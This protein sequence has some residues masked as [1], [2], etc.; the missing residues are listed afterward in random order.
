MLRSD[1]RA[2]HEY[3]ADGAVL[4]QGINARQYQYLLITKAASIGGYSLANGISHS[5]LKNR[6]NMMLHTKSPSQRYFK[7]LALLPIVAMALAVNAETVT[8]Y[9]YDE[10]QKQVP[11]K[12]GVK[13]GTIKMGN[14]EIKVVKAEE[15]KAETAET[16]TA[17]GSFEP[18]K[19]KAF[20]VVEEMP[21]YPGG[22]SKLFEYLARSVK[23]P[24]AAEKAGV[25][26]RVIATFVVETDGSISDIN[27]VK[28]VSPE[29]D[30]EAVRVIQGMPNWEPGKQ[31]GKEVRVKYTIPISFALSGQKSSSTTTDKVQIGG[32]KAIKEMVVVGFGENGEATSVQHPLVV[33]DGKVVEYE[34]MK[35]IDP[36][37]IDHM[38]ILKDKSATDKYGEKAKNGVIVITTKK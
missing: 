32:N 3:E 4:S 18:T 1:L 23:Y 5:T 15:K 16:P 20:D 38:E 19:E 17:V 28:S 12:K 36:H 25:Q 27:V 7:L 31:N 13:T 34:T 11:V 26:G 6:I 10:P 8:D 33:V 9:V 14:Q 37:T 21:R 35:S 30:A 2:I 24:A 29:L 22:A